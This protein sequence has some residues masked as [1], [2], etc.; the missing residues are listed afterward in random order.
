MTEPRARDHRHART[1]RRSAD[2][3][4]CGKLLPDIGMET[5]CAITLGFSRTISVKRS[6][7]LVLCTNRG[8]IG[9]VSLQCKSDSSYPVISVVQN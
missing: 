5:L 9:R 6:F 7:K 8:A 3:Q 1:R 4:M 2:P